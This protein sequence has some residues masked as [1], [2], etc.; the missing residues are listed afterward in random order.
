MGKVI[1]L[2]GPTMG[3]GGPAMG[4]GGPTMGFGGPEVDIA[5]GGPETFIAGVGFIA[6]LALLVDIGGIFGADEAEGSPVNRPINL[7]L[8][9][10]E[11]PAFILAA[12]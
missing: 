7:C 6:A 1:V 8:D 5:F 11:V 4:F 12:N 9:V 10:I 2:G 3:F